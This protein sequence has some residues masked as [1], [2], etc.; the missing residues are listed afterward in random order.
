MPVK[1]YERII[2][3]TE[4]VIDLLDGVVNLDS[5][6]SSGYKYKTDKVRTIGKNK[7]FIYFKFLYR[8]KASATV[9]GPKKK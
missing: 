5:E 1:R 2:T 7:D 6:G 3:T 4:K 8:G 9:A